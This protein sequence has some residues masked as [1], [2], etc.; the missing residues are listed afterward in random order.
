M[1]ISNV[2]AI[3]YDVEVND[4]FYKARRFLFLFSSMHLSLLSPLSGFVGRETQ[5]PC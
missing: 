2:F 4:L 3:R 5:V 1:E